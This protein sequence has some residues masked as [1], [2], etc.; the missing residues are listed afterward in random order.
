MITIVDFIGHSD[1]NGKPMGHP[2][3]V[4]NE[5]VD[6]LLPLENIAV[7]APSNHLNEIKNKDKIQTNE[8]SNYIYTFSNNKKKNLKKK[9]Q[10]LHTIFS[11]SKGVL[12]FINVDFSLFLYLFLFGSNKNKVWINLY[13]NPLRGSS[14]WREK[15]VRMVL[16]KL[17][18]VIVTNKNFLKTIPGNTIFIPDYYYKEELYSK[19]QTS[20]KKQQ[21][22]CLGT[23]GN[24]KQIEELIECASTLSFQ[25]LII[26]NFSQDMER[27]K[28]L[29]TMANTKPNIILKNKYVGND[30][31]YKLIA[32]S[33]YVILPYDM[34]LYN[35]RTSGILLETVFLDSIP[36]APQKLLA[37]NSIVGIGYEKLTDI[38]D[39]LIEANEAN[40][41]YENTRIR[42]TVFSKEAI[43]GIICK[44]LQS[45][46]DIIW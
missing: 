22:V 16:R 43:Q 46:K 25:V 3:K 20:E 39:I 4:I 24:T 6:L 41:V 15:I 29:E 45:K 23:M 35:E 9:W 40:I 32:E 17:D 38:H 31:Y 30:E 42:N 27:F 21:M 10:N 34:K 13:Y 5:I 44:Y 11:T 33:R 36:V 37:Y 14:G 1:K 18:L 12:W 19:Y 28:R 7:A 2:V 8:L 26:G